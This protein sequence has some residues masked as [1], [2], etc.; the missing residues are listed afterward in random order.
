MT[1]K[2]DQFS[3]I[4]AHADRGSKG[5]SLGNKVA[6]IKRCSSCGKSISNCLDWLQ[7]V[8][9]GE[10]TLLNGLNPSVHRIWSRQQIGSGPSVISIVSAH[11][12]VFGLAFQVGVSTWCLCSTFGDYITIITSFIQQSSLV[13]FSTVSMFK[14]LGIVVTVANSFALKPTIALLTQKI[15]K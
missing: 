11:P 6:V 15:Q 8:G 4:R 13:E 14:P 10:A 9:D 2:K 7:I 3:M 1:L 12:G 5:K